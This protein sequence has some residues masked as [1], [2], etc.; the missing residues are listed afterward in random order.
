[1]VTKSN[2]KSSQAERPVTQTARDVNPGAPAKIEMRA[3]RVST[4]EL[5]DERYDNVPCTD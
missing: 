4:P 3:E 2:S 1:M 5:V